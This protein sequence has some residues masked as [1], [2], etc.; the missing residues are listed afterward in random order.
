MCPRWCSKGGP[1]TVKYGPNWDKE[2]RIMVPGAT[3]IR[4]R[5]F[6]ITIGSGDKLGTSAGDVW[7]PGVYTDVLSSE[8]A[9]DRIFLR[10]RSDASV[11]GEFT[12]MMVEWQGDCSA[13]PEFSGELFCEPVPAPTAVTASDGTYADKVRVTWG[14]VSGATSYVILRSTTN[15]CDGATQI[16]TS[17]TTTYDDTTAEPCIRYY[18]FVKALKGVC[19]SPCSAGDSGWRNL[20]APTGVTATTDQCPVLVSW[21]AI[22]GIDCYQV[23]RNT[24]NDCSTATVIYTT[25]G[26]PFED[27]TGTPGTTYYYFVKACCSM[28]APPIAMAS[29][30]SAGAAGV[31]PGTEPC[32]P[33]PAPTGVTASD[34]T[35][36]HMVRITWDPV[37]G[38]TMYEILRSTTNKCDEATVIGWTTETMYGEGSPQPCTIYYYFVKAL[39]GKCASPCS[40]SD[41]GWRSLPAPTGVTATTTECPV[42]VNWTAWPGVECYQVLRNTTNDCSTATVIGTTPAPPF[43]DTTGTPGTTYYYFVKACCRMAAP[44]LEMVGECSAGAPGVCPVAAPCSADVQKIV[45]YGKN[46][47]QTGTISVT[48]ATKIRILFHELELNVGD[49]LASS[50]GDSWSGVNQTDVYSGWA[51]SSSLTLTLTSGP[52]GQGHFKIT[53]VEW[54]GD[55]NLTP[56]FGDSMFD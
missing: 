4:L 42:L 38:A 28:A 54:E 36:A 33:V 49:T 45:N 3:K 30:C 24:T 48:G 26:P 15:N 9:G 46:V 21:T 37:S 52:S 50:A 2:G 44:P 6:S 17:T 20:P 55:C 25:I 31:C 43:E 22:P 8:E 23:L 47:S 29:E 35:Y 5:F 11:N 53:K 14:S 39:K 51:N 1:W 32:D 19:A 41:S 12:I 40:S 56:I 18:Y 13:T 7:G 27:T 16:G 10:L 34:G